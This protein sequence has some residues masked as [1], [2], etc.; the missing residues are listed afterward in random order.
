[1]TRLLGRH[2]VYLIG[3]QGFR[4]LTSSHASLLSRPLPLG[5]KSKLDIGLSPG[6]ETTILNKINGLST[7]LGVINTCGLTTHGDEV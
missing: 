5:Q 6:I 7:Q 3:F 4:K 1:L 2:T